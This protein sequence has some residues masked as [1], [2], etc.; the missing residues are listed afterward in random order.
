MD[1]A[2]LIE[3]EHIRQLKYRYLR[4]LDQKRWEDMAGLFTE[5]ATAAYSGGKYS[6][7]FKFTSSG[8][9][10]IIRAQITN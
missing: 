6:H 10:R 1:A 8:E 3:I 7:T 5:D 4:F 2:E 9:V